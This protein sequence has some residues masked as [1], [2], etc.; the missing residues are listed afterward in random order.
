ME[1]MIL[2]WIHGFAAPPLD[3]AFGFSNWFGLFPLCTAVVTVMV[4]RHVLRRER[5]E[6]VVWVLVGLTAAI[7]PELIKLAAERPRPE[8]WQ[9]IVHASGFSFPSG[10]AMASA[11]FYPLVGWIL[12]RRN[13]IAGWVG[14]GLGAVF[15]LFVGFGRLYLG[16]HWPTD[17]LAGWLLGF[18]QSGVALAWL[19]RHAQRSESG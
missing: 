13:R 9:T 19:N 1:A 15:A 10:H 7:V 17:V 2:L 16:V 12:L 4:V 14:Y 11:A 3:L 18:T 8:L 5:T 6:A